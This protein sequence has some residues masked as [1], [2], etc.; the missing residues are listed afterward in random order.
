MKQGFAQEIDWESV[1]KNYEIM[2]LVY[3]ANE[4][5]EQITKKVNGGTNGLSRKKHAT[6]RNQKC[7]Y[8]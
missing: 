4:R 5:F 2:I 7:Q 3:L 8:F 6:H 1:H